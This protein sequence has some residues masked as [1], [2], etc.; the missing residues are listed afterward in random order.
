MPVGVDPHAFAIPGSADVLENL[1]RRSTAPA[2]RTG[3]SRHPELPRSAWRSST[4]P[5]REQNLSQLQHAALR[6]LQASLASERQAEKS[7][8]GP[9]R[10][11]I[12]AR[13]TCTLLAVVWLIRSRRELKDR[14]P[15][16]ISKNPARIADSSLAT[17]AS[18]R[19]NRSSMCSNRFSVSAR[20]CAMSARIAVTSL[21][22]RS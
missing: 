14:K 4:K 2:Q 22:R 21:S 7:N 12:A 1:P 18:S 20:S 6:T 19:S 9:S 13:S 10:L 17:L 8:H 16:C 15:A 3:S 11:P 5:Q